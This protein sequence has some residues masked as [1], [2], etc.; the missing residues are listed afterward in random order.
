MAKLESTHFF[1]VQ[2]GKITVWPLLVDLQVRALIV[3]APPRLASVQMFH[4][5]RGERNVALTVEW[6]RAWPLAVFAHLF[7]RPWKL[8]HVLDLVAWLVLCE[9]SL[10]RLVWRSLRAWRGRVVHYWVCTTCDQP[11]PPHTGI[12]W[13]FWFGN[14]NVGIN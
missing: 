7:Q 8:W 11:L 10:Y 4:A 6:T 14:S 5:W 12:F 13:K 3:W 9:R 2:P 1:R